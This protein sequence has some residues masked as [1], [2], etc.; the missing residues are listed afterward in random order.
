MAEEVS[1]SLLQKLETNERPAKEEPPKEAALKN[2]FSK[3]AVKCEKK[4]SE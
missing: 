3:E 2:R 4:K 1:C